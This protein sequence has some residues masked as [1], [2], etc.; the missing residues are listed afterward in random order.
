MKG[1]A[2]LAAATAIALGAGSCALADTLDDVKTRGAVV[3]GV[4]Q[5]L[6]GF[7]AS[8]QAGHWTGFDVDF[9]RAV[10][11]AVLGDASKSRIV[12]LSAKDRLGALASGRID[13]LTRTT[14]RN[15]TWKRG[16]ASAPLPLTLAATTYFDGQGFMINTK[17]LSGINSAL[18]LSGASI[19]VN[20]ATP[21]ELNAIDYFRSKKMEYQLVKFDKADEAVA[22]YDDDQC[23]VYT[24]DLSGLYAQRLKLTHPADHAILPEVISRDP[25]GPAV[26][27][28]DDQWLNIVK[29]THFAMV[30]A[31][32]DGVASSNVDAMKKSDS[33]EIRRLLGVEGN[34]GAGLGLASGWAYDV[35]KQVGNYGEVFDRNVGPSTPLGIARGLNALWSKGG[36]QYAP[37]IR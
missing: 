2:L 31:E 1:L 4:D 24:T 11:A 19:C 33:P 34:F 26:R 17:K 8:D 12:P 35:I 37:P 36:L 7:A 9:C 15:A 29:W 23:Q 30:D 18:Q 5:G 27:Q 10:A 28:G 20:A 32:E 21:A 25:L 14:S 22:A 13:L 6:A 16:D 3:C